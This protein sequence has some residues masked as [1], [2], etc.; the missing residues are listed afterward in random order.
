MS[1]THA[2]LVGTIG[3]AV[4]FSFLCSVRKD[5][6]RPMIYSGLLYAIF[7]TFCFV[8]LKILSQDP[9]K[10]VSPGYWSPPSLFDLN[11][12]TGGEGIED[13]LF[14]FFA[15]AIIAGIYELLFSIKINK[16]INKSL[17][18]GHAI[19][20]GFVASSAIFAFTPINAMYFLI[21]L[22]L[23][24]AAAIVW[25]RRDLLMHSIAGG[26]LF[27]LLYGVLFAVFNLLYPSFISNFDHLQRTT[28]ILFLGVPL[29]EYLY[30]LSMGLMWAPIYE[31]MHQVKDRSNKHQSSRLRRVFLVAALTRR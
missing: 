30:A 23:F 26:I 15:P 24:G 4:I 3:L 17:K 7:M 28:H 6:R 31:Y 27:T 29:E 5:L 8:W 16:K 14:M 25:Q 19:L 21:F 2:Y 12:K 9:A 20:I 13:L 11:K 22:Q 1:E 18:R 10:S